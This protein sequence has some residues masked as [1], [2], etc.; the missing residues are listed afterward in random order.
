MKVNLKR[1][2]H[3]GV[4]AD[5]TET[6]VEAAGAVV[7]VETTEMVMMAKRLSRSKLKNQRAKKMIAKRS[8]RRS[9]HHEVVEAVVA[10]EVGAVEV[11][12][13]TVDVR[14]RTL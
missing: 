10:P 12:V 11:A 14:I 5:A 2:L 9:D 7:D 3:K 6:A 13:A 4:G 8:S 1:A